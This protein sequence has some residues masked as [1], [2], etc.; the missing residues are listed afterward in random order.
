M[1]AVNCDIDHEWMDACRD[2]DGCMQMHVADMV[3]AGARTYCSY[4]KQY[5]CIGVIF[6]LSHHILLVSVELTARRRQPRSEPKTL[7]SLHKFTHILYH[8]I[9][10][11]LHFIGL[12][13]IDWTAS[14]DEERTEDFKLTSQIKPHFIAFYTNSISFYWGQSNWL[15]GFGTRGAKRRL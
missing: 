4:K 1:L 12:S 5:W 3:A 6:Y 15:E 10:I 2:I 11:Q 7:S 13:Q 14:A 9:L 8:F